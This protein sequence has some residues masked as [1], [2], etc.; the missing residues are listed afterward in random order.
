M[1]F[2]VVGVC[3]PARSGPI[4][5][6]VVMDEEEVG[7]QRSGTQSKVKLGDTRI[8]E[9]VLLISKLGLCFKET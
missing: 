9:K 7:R 5:S 2:G 4:W 3:H 6:D 1:Y 8:S